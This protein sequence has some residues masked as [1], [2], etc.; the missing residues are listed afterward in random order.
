MVLALM[1][2][3]DTPQ[4]RSGAPSASPRS[5]AT[6]AV[7]G[8]RR[9]IAGGYGIP[10][11]REEPQKWQGSVSR[12]SRTLWNPGA[13]TP[14][15]VAE[16]LSR[17]GLDMQQGTRTLGQTHTKAPAVAAMTMSRAS[18]RPGAF[19]VFPHRSVCG[20]IS[21]PEGGEMV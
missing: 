19:S 15:S 13:P 6:R 7:P 16:D 9:V 8:C 4:L 11:T 20:R 18:L 17:E 3:D 12:N 5:L 2:P 1:A 21:A 10:Q 14:D